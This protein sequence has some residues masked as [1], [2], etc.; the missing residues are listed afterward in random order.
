M[1][2][3]FQELENSLTH[4][5]DNLLLWLDNTEELYNRLQAINKDAIEEYR[6]NTTWYIK[7]DYSMKIRYHHKVEYRQLLLDAMLYMEN[8]G[9]FEST[10]T[11]KDIDIRKMSKYLYLRELANIR[12]NC[13]TFINAIDTIKEILEK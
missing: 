7:Q 1:E 8:N 5:E 11:R 13:E 12:F 4:S 2:T 10:C 9:E 6:Y 3:K